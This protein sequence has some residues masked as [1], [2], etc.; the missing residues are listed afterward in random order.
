MCIKIKGYKITRKVELKDQ[1]IITIK[2]INDIII[3]N[4]GF[5]EFR[6]ATS[7][8]GVYFINTDFISQI[9]DPEFKS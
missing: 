4:N 2:N 8:G 1:K 3:N 9:F 5:V 6:R 7:N